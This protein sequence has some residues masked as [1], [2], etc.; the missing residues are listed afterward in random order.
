[1]SAHRKYR[2]PPSPAR[3]AYR[4]APQQGWSRRNSRLRV[5]D[6]E[7]HAAVEMT[8]SARLRRLPPYGP[9]PG[10]HGCDCD[11]YRKSRASCVLICPSGYITAFIGRNPSIRAIAADGFSYFLKTERSQGRWPKASYRSAHGFG[12]IDGKQKADRRF[13][14]IKSPP[15]RTKKRLRSNRRAELDFSARLKAAGTRSPLAAL[16][17]DPLLRSAQPADKPDFRAVAAS[18]LLASAMISS[19]LAYLLFSHHRG[20]R[21]G[22]LYQP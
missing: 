2:A 15:L 6:I 9:V 5:V 21:C 16:H 12:Q 3:L 1:M 14:S 4:A 8:D 18:S 19:A 20:T 22:P 11:P 13:A 7:P 10:P 17:P